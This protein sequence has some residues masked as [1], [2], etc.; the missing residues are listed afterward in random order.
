MQRILSTDGKGTRAVSRAEKEGPHKGEIKGI[1]CPDKPHKAVSRHP[2]R[3]L[4]TND[5]LKTVIPSSE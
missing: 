1:F 4:N 2:S 5:I 3:N